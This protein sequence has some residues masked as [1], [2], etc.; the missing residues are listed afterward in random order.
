MRWVLAVVLAGC[1]SSQQPVLPDAQPSDA[2]TD[3][4]PAGPLD[5]RG[6]S[7][8]FVVTDRFANGD[9]S[10]DGADGFASNLTDPRAWHGGD[11]QGLID[12]LDYI[13]G[14][15]FTGLWIT[16][17]IAQ[18]DAR[19]YHGYWG[20]DWSRIDPHLGD[21]AKLRELVAAA[22]ARNIAVMIDTV[23]N[24]TGRYN[25]TTPSFPDAAMYHHNGNITDY[26]NAAQVENN[27][28]SG[29]DDLAQE[30][31]TVRE[32]L[33]DHVRWLVETSGADGLRVDTVKHVP[34]AFWTDWRAAANLFSI[35]EV[36]SGGVEAVAP[37]SHILDAALDYPLY[38]AMQSTFA[39][40]GS[41]R[42][43]GAVLAKDAQ[44]ADAQLGG[45]F[46]D[47]HDQPR[48][49][50]D[51]TTGD[52]QTQLRLALAFAFTTRG[53]PILYYG[54]EQGFGDCANNRQDMFGAADASAATYRYIAELN[55]IR[56]STEALRTGLQRERWQD[57]T[58][59]AFEREV[60]TSAAVVAFNLSNAV[61]TL[62]LKN[63]HVPPGTTFVDALGSGATFTV[64]AAQ[65]LAVRVPA[66]AVVILTATP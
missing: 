46:I 9:A 39:K 7:I 13:A 6:R 4:Q 52:K 44:Y 25:F 22:H 48:F 58:A 50:C 18:H 16:P 59:Y 2:T 20:W 24:H 49:L 29:L 33:L 10:N 34:K 19:A 61:R 32:R 12:R 62:P 43:L 45:I 17:V 41:A 3:A 26:N 15:G 42:Q 55:R 1:V 38:Y 11:F 47:N 14:M 8:Y 27:A 56:A 53:L 28:L 51:A 54:T 23:A 60:G 65:Q 57:D 40:G 36:L 63:L 64:D 37:Y 30:N 35:G 66:H 5:W 31:P 21:A